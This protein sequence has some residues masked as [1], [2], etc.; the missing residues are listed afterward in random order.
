MKFIRY[1]VLINIKEWGSL[2][3]AFY[4]TGLLKGVGWGSGGGSLMLYTCSAI[5]NLLVALVIKA[6]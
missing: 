4:V 2:I 6:S 1:E 3:M 5:S